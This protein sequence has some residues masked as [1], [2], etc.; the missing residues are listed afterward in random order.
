MAAWRS[1]TRVIGQRTE[2]LERG[3]F[4]ASVRFLATRWRWG[5]HVVERFLEAAQKRGHILRQREGQGGAVYLVV[6][7]GAKRSTSTE[8]GTPTGTGAGTP[9]GHLGD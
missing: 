5:K 1:W 7:Y 4:I 3:E 8:K 9:R 6:N 2:R